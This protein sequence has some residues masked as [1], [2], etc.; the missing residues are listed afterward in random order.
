[1][2]TYYQKGHEEKAIEYQWVR[3]D[4]KL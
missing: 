3:A 4:L 1:M 2:T